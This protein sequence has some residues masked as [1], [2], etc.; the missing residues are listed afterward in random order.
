MLNKE[1][2]NNMNGTN[3]TYNYQISRVKKKSK[4]KLFDPDKLPE[5]LEGN[6]FDKS[7][8]FLRG[9]AKYINVID[10]IDNYVY[11]HT[12]FGLRLAIK[13]LL[14][15][16]EY[17]GK[18][19]P[20]WGPALLIANHQSVLD[21]FLIAAAIP[22]EIN[23]M[24]KI[25]NFNM[26][27]FKSILSFYGTFGVNRGENPSVVLDM[28]IERLKN[29]KCVGMFPGGTRSPTTDLNPKWKTGAARIVLKARVPYVPA[30]II[31]SHY[32]LP[33]NSVKLNLH[34]VEIRVG[35][36]VYLDYSSYDPDSYKDVRSITDYMKE[37]VQDLK[38]AEVD[39]VSKTLIMP[40]SKRAQMIARAKKL[41]LSI[42]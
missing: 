31:D 34:P 38:D 42:W 27:I 5:M 9:F 37:Q 17:G 41:N 14:Q 4:N 1:E 8:S 36:P 40:K 12:Y 19:F 29:G 10:A 18:N 30:C 28:A 22:R 16:R 33:K 13:L 20:E 2:M 11:W 15:W 32:V 26:P 39:P 7:V 23:W 35:K 3:E 24:S 25:E 21:P 6:I